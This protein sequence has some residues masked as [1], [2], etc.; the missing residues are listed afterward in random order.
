MIKDLNDKAKSGELPE[1]IRDMVEPLND[2]A[3]KYDENHPRVLNVQE[4]LSSS[5]KRAICREKQKTLTTGHARVDALTGGIRPG[6]VWV[7]GADTSWGK[8]SWLVAMADENMNHGARVL[9]VSTEDSETLYADRLM[10][11]RSRVRAWALRDRCLNAEELREVTRV[12]A[13]AKPDPVWMDG[14]GVPVERLC[15]MIRAAIKE[16]AIDIVCVDY[17]QEVK[18]ER[19]YQDRRTEIAEIASQLRTTIKACGVCGV[20]ASQ[21]TVTDGKKTPDKHSIRESRDVPNAAEVVIL[22]YNSDEIIYKVP[23]D[24]RSEV[25]AQPGDKV[26]KI[27]KAKD[28]ERGSAVLSWN[29]KSACFEAVKEVGEYDHLCEADNDPPQHWQ[30]EDPSL[31]P[32]SF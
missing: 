15:K 21:I 6:H 13:E 2:A 4:L 18:S 7:L 27:D 28:G 9:I 10:A 23:G 3:R 31:D 20:I 5:M 24:A 11:R 26:L 17:L 1:N 29:S 14:R 12:V 22:G 32:D 19:R 30:E 8:S 16:H 25:V